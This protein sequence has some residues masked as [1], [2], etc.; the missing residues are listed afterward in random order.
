MIEY[1]FGVMSSKWKL[2]A[3]DDITAYVTMSLKVGRDVPIAVFKPKA[4]VFMPLDIL[5]DND[6]TFDRELVSNCMDTIIE[7]KK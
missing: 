4:L 2:E 6:K 5:R 3:D 7:V 1:E